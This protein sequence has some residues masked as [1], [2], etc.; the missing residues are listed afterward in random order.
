[1][2]ELQEVG[3]QMKREKEARERDAMNI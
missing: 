1:L 3:L 2:K